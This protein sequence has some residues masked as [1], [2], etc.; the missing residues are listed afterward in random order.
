[1]PRTAIDA[2]AEGWIPV[3]TS[4]ENNGAYSGFRY[5]KPNETAIYMMYDKNGIISGMQAL[6]IIYFCKVP[7]DIKIV[8]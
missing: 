8:C 5:T 1:M 7:Y 2:V 4:C 6:V 3:S